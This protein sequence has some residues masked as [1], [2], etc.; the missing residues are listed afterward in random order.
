MAKWENS[1]A[2]ELD[3]NQQH[4]IETVKDTGKVSHIDA[5]ALTGTRCR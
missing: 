4:F 1:E 5:G 2:K 3:E